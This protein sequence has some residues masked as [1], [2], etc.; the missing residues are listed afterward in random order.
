M[1]TAPSYGERIFQHFQATWPREFE[2]SK[3]SID[4]EDLRAQ[5]GQLTDAPEPGSDETA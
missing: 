2:I 1:M 5:L 4:N 3:L